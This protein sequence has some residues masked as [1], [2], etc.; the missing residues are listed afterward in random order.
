MPY[1]TFGKTGPRTKA[2][3]RLHRF[4]RSGHGAYPVCPMLWNSALAFSIPRTFNP[5]GGKI[6]TVVR[7]NINNFECC[8]LI[9]KQKVLSCFRS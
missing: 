3:P 7:R 1:T 2:L 9:N 6:K 5:R 8:H 4:R